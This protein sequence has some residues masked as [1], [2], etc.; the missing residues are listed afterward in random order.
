[1]WRMD[2]V[3]LVSQGHTFVISK[4]GK[5][6]CSWHLLIVLSLRQRGVFVLP[7]TEN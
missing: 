5:A 3:S 4:H 7:L 1:M 6:A 2:T